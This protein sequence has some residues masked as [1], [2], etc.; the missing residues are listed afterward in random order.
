MHESDDQGAVPAGWYTD[1]SPRHQYRYWDGTSLTDRVSD[2]GVETVDPLEANPRYASEAAAANL[3]VQIYLTVVM[4]TTKQG[5]QY[6][7]DEEVVEKYGTAAIPGLVSLLDNP[8]KCYKARNALSKLGSAAVGPLLAK[9]AERRS[10]KSQVLLVGIL[11]ESDDPAAA[12]AVAS[13]VARWKTAMQTYGRTR[14]QQWWLSNRPKEPVCDSCG[15]P[16]S[17]ED[18]Y[19][20]TSSMICG[21]CM[22]RAMDR[23]DFSYDWFG[24]GTTEAAFALLEMVVVVERPREL[25]WAFF[26]EPANWE[27]WWG[28]AVKAAQWREGGEVEWASGGSSRIAAL[29]P[30]ESVRLEGT[31]VD[32]TFVFEPE[33]NGRTAV[34]I[35]EG[36][37]KGGAYFKDG[38]SAH[39][40]QLKTY[41]AQLKDLIEGETPLASEG[42]TDQPLGFCDFCGAK[43]IVAGQLHCGSCG[44]KLSQLSEV[45]LGPVPGGSVAAA[46]VATEVQAVPEVPV[47][48]AM[49]VAPSIPEQRLAEP[50]VLPPP[51]V[52]IPPPPWATTAPPDAATPPPAAY[53]LPPPPPAAPPAPAVSTPAPIPPAP[54]ADDQQQ[55]GQPPAGPSGAW[56]PPPS[57]PGGYAPGAPALGQPPQQPGWAQPD[58]N[59]KWRQSL[60]VW[61]AVARPLLPPEA[62]VRQVIVGSNKS[63]YARWTMLRWVPFLRFAAYPF[64]FVRNKTS[65]IF[66]VAVADD[67]IYVIEFARSGN[68]S[69]SW[70]ATRIAAVLPR[71]TRLGPPA[72]R[73]TRIS[74]GTTTLYVSTRNNRDEILAADAWSQPQG[75]TGWAQPS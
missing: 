12:Q 19:L 8:E 27:R 9:L 45:A 67:A 30:C 13:F 41:L 59:D 2:K 51:V 70:R 62:V 14:A 24:P 35:M 22:T 75:A 53:P 36:I 68:F 63:R 48:P 25:V 15:D 5:R 50:E 29:A 46:Q 64:L 26:T 44:Q 20:H 55:S 54:V 43:R 6:C 65:R 49:P 21:K 1:P 66:A 74:L 60:Q 47:A 56:P 39:H 34:R 32:T 16:V 7:F 72:G 28:G 69:S 40:E 37:P 3:R 33:D 57:Q 73:E 58:T 71:A 42:N 38:G 10:L 17:V 11:N 4:G 31:F 23:W 52:P 18:S 61:I